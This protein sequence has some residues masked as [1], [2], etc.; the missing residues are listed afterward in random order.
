MLLTASLI[1]NPDILLSTEETQSKQFILKTDFF[2]EMR[3]I[4]NNCQHIYS[5]PKFIAKRT[6]NLIM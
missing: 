1:E 4:G 2:E 6:G 3:R 5:L